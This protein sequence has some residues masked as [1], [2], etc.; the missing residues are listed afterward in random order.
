MNSIITDL[1]KNIQYLP[2]NE[3]IIDSSLCTI[4]NSLNGIFLFNYYNFRLCVQL[5]RIFPFTNYLT[6][7]KIKVIKWKFY[8]CEESEN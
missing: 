2:N 3:G 7:C 4:N 1:S 6:G 8:Q 5:K